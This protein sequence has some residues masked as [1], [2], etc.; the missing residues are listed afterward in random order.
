MTCDRCNVEMSLEPMGK[1]SQIMGWYCPCCKSRLQTV[2][3]IEEDAK[4]RADERGVTV[5][6]LFEET[7]ALISHEPVDDQT[8]AYF[9]ELERRDAERKPPCEHV[10]PAWE[11]AS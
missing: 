11:A 9:T 5:E 3:M 1:G 6:E 2:E 4:R 7:W 8:L 10:Y